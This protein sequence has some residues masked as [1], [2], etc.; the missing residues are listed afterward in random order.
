MP[1]WSLPHWTMGPYCSGPPGSR[2]PIADLRSRCL[3][4][5]TSS[6]FSRTVIP[7]G[8]EPWFPACEAGVVATGPRDQK[9][10]AYGCRSRTSA[11]TGQ[12]AVPLHQG[13]SV[14]V[15][16]GSRTHKVTTPSRWPLYQVC[17]PG[18]FSCRPRYRS[19]LADLMRVCRA[20]ARLHN[21]VT[22]GRVELPMPLARPSL[23]RAVCL[24]VPPLGQRQ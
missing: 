8:L 12:H 20:P 5:W 1:C 17:V 18:R 11:S 21:S 4:D 9:S 14:S 3:A 6:P 19:G 2:T 15:R 10:G 7:H 23:L 22:K 16:G 24:P 13:T